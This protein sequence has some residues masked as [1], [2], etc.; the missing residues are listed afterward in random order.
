MSEHPVSSFPRPDRR[1][2]LDDRLAASGDV[3]LGPRLLSGPLGAVAVARARPLASSSL[4]KLSMS[5]RRTANKASERT[6]HQVVNWRRSSADASLVRPQYP[7]RNPAR[8][9]RSASVKAGWI[10]ASAVD[11]AA[12]VIGHLPAGLEPGKLGQFRSQRLTE[13]QYFGR[14]QES[15]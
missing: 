3:L 7:V 10:V 5:A 6:R 2:V 14:Q 13:T 1:D 11:G 9:S 4:A 12:V 8:A 15:P